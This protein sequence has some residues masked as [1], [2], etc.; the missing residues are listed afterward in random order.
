MMGEAQRELQQ[1]PLLTTKLAIPPVRSYL[2]RRLRLIERLNDGLRAKLTLITAP[3][4]FGKTTL[5]SEWISHPDTRGKTTAWVSLDVSDNDPARF[6]SYVIAALQTHDEGLGEAALTLLQSLQPLPSETI[7]TVLINAITAAQR[8]VTTDDLVLV[9]D[10]FHVITTA[11]IHTAV[12]FL[13]DHMPPHMHLVITSRSEPPLALAMLRAYGQLVELHA[14]DLR[15]TSDEATAFL[16]VMGL[17]LAPEEVAKLEQHTEGWITALHLAALS[18]QGQPD[19][20]SFIQAFTGSHRYVVDYLT[21]TVFNRQPPHI[22]AFLL[23]TAV[24]DRLCGP[25]CAAMLNGDGTQA[26]QGSSTSIDQPSTESDDGYSQTMLAHLERAN[27]FIMP[28]DTERR[29]YRYHQIFADFLR[30]RLQQLQPEQVVHL[31]LRAADWYDQQGMAIDAI[32]HALAAD[33]IQAARLIEQSARPMLMRSEVAT[34]IGWL[35]ALPEVLVRSRA[36]LSVIYAWALVATG[37]LN[38]GE[39]HLQD[40]ERCL[41]GPVDNQGTHSVARLQAEIMAIRAAMAGMYRDLNA[42]ITLAHQ[43][44]ASLPKDMVYLRGIVALMLGGAYHLSGHVAEANQA[45]AEA[46]QLSLAVGNITVAIFATR[47]LGELQMLQARLQQ[48][49]TIYQQM[50]D[51]C[52]EWSGKPGQPALSTRRQPLP[53]AGMAYVGMSEVLYEWNDLDG[54]LRYIHD[55]ISFG[56]QSSNVEILLRGHITLAHIQYARGYAYEAAAALQRGVQIAHDTHIPR[57][58]AW[59]AAEQARLWILQGNLDPAERWAQ[60]YGVGPDD[61]LLYLR[62]VDHLILVRLLIAQDQFDT[63]LRLLERLLQAAELQ[64]RTGSVIEIL[65][66]QAVALYVQDDLS[67]SSAA[68][69]RA[70]ALAE[71]EGYIRTFLDAGAAIAELLTHVA[72]RTTPTTAY[73]CRLLADCEARQD[74]A[75]RPTQYDP[76]SV[77]DIAEPLSEREMSVLRLIALG[78]SNQEIAAQLV[79]TV[80]TVKKH[81]NHIYAKLEVRSRTKALA[82]AREL[83]LLS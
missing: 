18:M 38:D 14:I 16:N 59:M 7:L 55:G 69:Q 25:L 33:N 12:G 42:T 61:E 79:V 43:A 53:I 3:P 11:A 13:L 22:Q 28:L 68:I 57:L 6:W 67:Q 24:L 2:I 31:H 74:T 21:E 66:M 27:L 73:T 20:S 39:I 83:N 36:D 78:M 46:Q 48:A 47:Q 5:V 71:P 30:L 40:A 65:A 75:E 8:S 50:I 29:W 77:P 63:A 37:Q 54:A 62:E 80:S 56:E 17:G 45:L 49:A 44:L 64:Q 15:F 4:G 82:R 32:H 19:V 52:T 35:E 76:L 72:Q 51:L 10:D 41:E 81:I 23:Q 26:D 58:I 60:E 9:L 70:L 34:V 1:L